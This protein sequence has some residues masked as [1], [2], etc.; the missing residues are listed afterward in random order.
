MKMKL[1]K[2]EY[3]RERVYSYYKKYKHF[4][5]KL[6]IDHFISEGE[7]KSTIYNIINRSESG[8]PSK[9]QQGGGRPAKIF[10]QKAKKKLKRLVN[11]KDGVSQRKLASRFK[12]TQ[13][14]C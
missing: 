5:K 7:S 3:L 2:R 14:T 12:C 4:G 9:H 11:N 10:N 1:S 8:K 6:T 13:T